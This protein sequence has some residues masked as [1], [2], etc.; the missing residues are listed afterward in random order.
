MLKPGGVFLYVFLSAIGVLWVAE[1]KNQVESLQTESN[2]LKEVSSVV[3]RKDSRMVPVPIPVANPTLGTGLAGAL[4]YLHPSRS[5]DPNAPTSTT[6]GRIA[7]VQISH[8]DGGPLVRTPGGGRKGAIEKTFRSDLKHQLLSVVME[9]PS[10][11]RLRGGPNR[12]GI[13]HPRALRVQHV[14]M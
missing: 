13:D 3:L 10:H 14:Y 7:A 9:N 12:V 6:G 4:L 8:L 5:S 2:E 1:I 11:A